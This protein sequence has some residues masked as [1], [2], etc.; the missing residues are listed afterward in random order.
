MTTYDEFLEGKA[1]IASAGGLS[2]DP[3]D[4][5][6]EMFGF[7]KRLAAWALS[8][9]RAAVFADCGLGKTVMQLAVADKVSRHTDM[10]VLVL[11]PLAVASQTEREASK[12][13]LGAAVSRDGH[14][15]DR[16]VVTNY[17][18]L[19]LFDPDD[20]GGCVCDESSILKSFDG[21]TRAMVTDFMR[22][23]RF[24]FLFTATAAPN[25]YTELG[26][27]S[28][29]LG[30]L[31]YM[32]MLSRFFVNDQG[33]SRPMVY[34]HRGRNFAQLDEGAK[35]RFKGHAETPFWRWVSSW[36]RAI[37]KPS[38][39][40][41]EDDGFILPELNHELEIVEAMSAA[42]GSLFNLP[43]RGLTEEREEQRRTVVERC[44][45]AAAIALEPGPCVVWCQLNQEGDLLERLIPDAVQ[46]KGSDTV[47]A[48]E[49]RLSAFTNGDARVLITKPKIGAWGL[50]WQHC[51][52]MVMFPS[53]SYEQYY[54][55][56][57]RCWRFGQ[58]RP[59]TVHIVTTEGGAHALESLQRKSD[60]ADRMFTE[61]VRHM[62]DAIGIDKTTYDNKMERPTWL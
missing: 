14:H 33:T 48:K 8:Q 22:R 38:D 49:E 52:R 34:R 50:N 7:Q 45:R 2:I 29:A 51:N 17:Q 61:L 37:R 59:V 15:A 18:R 3:D 32:D 6:G 19:H 56:V 39:M 47:E 11:T 20:F 27:S 13:H 5:P 44:E 16:I 25:D 26:T 28:E 57:R 1:S 54:Q 4:L 58:T 55:A 36:A 9:S 40:G 35:W 23:M 30:H 53:H 60:A 21:T 62:S 42:P 12:F 46:V 31:G 24:R 10:P 41:F 43:A